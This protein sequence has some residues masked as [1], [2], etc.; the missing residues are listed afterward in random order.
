MNTNEILLLK[1]LNPQNLIIFANLKKSKTIAFLL[2]LFLGG[3]GAQWF[4]MGKTAA[5]VLSIL[6]CWTFIP[7]FISL[8]ALFFISS[9]VDKYN[10]KLLQ[11][12]VV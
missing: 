8:I 7:S 1:Q 9:M 10:L 11:A 12:L 2:T 5:G 4:Y 3:V 6:F